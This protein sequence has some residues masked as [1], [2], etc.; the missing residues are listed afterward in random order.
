MRMSER[1]RNLEQKTHVDALPALII[2]V[3]EDGMVEIYGDNEGEKVRM[4]E[5]EYT[6]WAKRYQ[7]KR[8]QMNITIEMG[9]WDLEE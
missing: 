2:E 1:I 8:D 4:T 7:K 3:L 6:S 5:A 9:E